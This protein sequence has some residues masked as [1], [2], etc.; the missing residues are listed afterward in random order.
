V[1]AAG[2]RVTARRTAFVVAHRLATAAASDRIVVL[3]RGRFVEEGPHR[4][5]LEANGRYAALWR[6]GELEPVADADT[7]DHSTVRS[8]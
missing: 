3:H 2:D 6:A 1:L 8:A 7:E 5:L 4:D